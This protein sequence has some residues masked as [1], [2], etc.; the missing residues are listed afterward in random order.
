MVYNN[1]VDSNTFW[2]YLAMYNN[3]NSFDE[4]KGQHDSFPEGSYP[5]A[6]FCNY[7]NQVI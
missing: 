4:D 1:D 5:T 7:R 3:E 2:R 6:D